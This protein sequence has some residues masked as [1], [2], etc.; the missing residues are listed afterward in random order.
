MK[1]K[2]ILTW[3]AG[4]AVGTAGLAATQGLVR[5]HP[6]PAT[7]TQELSE[8]EREGWAQQ[9]TQPDLDLREQAYERALAAAA[10]QPGLRSA[11]E[12][13]AGDTPD[14]QLAWTSRL[15]LRELGRAHDALHGLAVP[16]PPSARAMPMDMEQLWRQMA[17]MH[18]SLEDLFE[19]GEGAAAAAP[20]QGDSVTSQGLQLRVGPD[21]VECEVTH[22]ED[23]RRVTR[24]YQAA[25]LQELIEQHPELEARL[26]ASGAALGAGLPGRA[27]AG[28]SASEGGLAPL[29]TDVL[30]VVVASLDPGRGAAL[31]LPAGLGLAVERVEP[32]TIAAA[33]GIRRGHVL[34]EL[35][36]RALRQSEDISSVLSERAPDGE[37]RLVLLD[38]YGQ[39]RR[40]AWKPR[41]SAAPTGAEPE[42]P[43]PLRPPGG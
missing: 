10:R 31:G 30:G 13:W 40:R 24:R 19:L 5:L 8:A 2:W 28:A 17:E 33:L 27:R 18:G 34:L 4:L 22:E 14:G 29:R 26:E 23:G 25:S 37:L 35:N 15:L 41:P 3:V 11:L 7:A 16:L 42:P 43:R 38:R 6:R 39:E 21:G 12:R 36:G 20:P 1:R 9:L 32:G